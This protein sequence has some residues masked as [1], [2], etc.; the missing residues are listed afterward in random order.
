[1]ECS[2][3]PMVGHMTQRGQSQSVF[4]E[5]QGKAVVPAETVGIKDTEAWELRLTFSVAMLN[6]KDS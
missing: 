4:R 3:W 2:D 5:R 6:R 1:M